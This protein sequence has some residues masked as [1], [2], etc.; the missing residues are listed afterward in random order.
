MLMCGVHCRP[1]GCFVLSH[2]SRCCGCEAAAVATCVTAARTEA[3]CS[4][5]WLLPRLD[6]LWLQ[7][8]STRPPTLFSYTVAQLLPVRPVGSLV[9]VVHMTQ[10]SD[11]RG[12]MPA[13]LHVIALIV[14]P[15]Q[16]VCITGAWVE[17]H[18]CLNKPLAHA[19]VALVVHHVAVHQRLHGLLVG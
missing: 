12:G 19:C 3:E 10:H 17:V 18:S 14:N 11:C 5:W 1:T 8:V 13:V 15:R 6:T 16:S 4:K 7:T 9:H 2:P